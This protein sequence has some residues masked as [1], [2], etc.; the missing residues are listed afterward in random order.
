MSPW[1][2]SALGS[3][4][5]CE[6]GGGGCMLLVAEDDEAAMGAGAVG[7]PLAGPGITCCSVAWSGG[8][9]WG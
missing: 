1:V 9:G 8:W 3:V 5:I 7:V 4:V 6:G 2:L